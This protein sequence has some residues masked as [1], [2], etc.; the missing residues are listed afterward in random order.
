[1]TNK[2]LYLTP[3]EW[4]IMESLWAGAP[5]LGSHIVKDLQDSV[6][7][8]RSTTLT[9]L[10]RMRDKGYIM[11]RTIKGVKAYFPMLQR[12]A[13]VLKETEQFLDRVYDGDFAL[14]LSTYAEQKGLTAAELKALHEILS[15]Y[16]ERK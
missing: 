14:L 5:K 4:H 15:T 1:M 6:G 9:M 10:K 16:E 11:E 13:E 2:N 12:N 7:W 3:S 8:N